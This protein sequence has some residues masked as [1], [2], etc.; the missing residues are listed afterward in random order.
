MFKV[1]QFI[2]ELGPNKKPLKLVCLNILWLEILDVDFF[3]V[4]ML[5][6]LGQNRILLLCFRVNEVLDVFIHYDEL[7]SLQLSYVD[8]LIVVNLVLL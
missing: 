1:L 7:G 2:K 4:S 8:A 6:L 5:S 3:D